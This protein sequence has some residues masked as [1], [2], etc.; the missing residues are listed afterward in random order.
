M[1]SVTLV[2]LKMIFSNFLTSLIAE[3]VM[4]NIDVLKK[5]KFKELYQIIMSCDLFQSVITTISVKYLLFLSAGS[6]NCPRPVWSGPQQV[7][8]P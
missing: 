3:H 8:E 7:C 1:F 2:Y 6:A 4:I 5:M